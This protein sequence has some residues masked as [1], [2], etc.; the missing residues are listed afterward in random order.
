MK[1]HDITFNNT[2][3]AAIKMCKE[4]LDLQSLPTIELVDKILND[5]QPSFG[6]F[7]NNSIK[8]V[9]KDRHIIDCVR[10]LAHELIHWKQRQL[11][12]EMDGSD[13]SETENQANAGAG[14]IMRRFGKEYPECFTL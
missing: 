10:T 9:V 1:I 11:G 5:D 3:R 8:I 13:G 2:I 4:E 7:E 6:I 12:L 14:I